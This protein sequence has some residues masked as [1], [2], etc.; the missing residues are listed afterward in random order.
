MPRLA[1]VIYKKHTGNCKFCWR[2]IS[3]CEIRKCAICQT[4]CCKKC[5]GEFDRE[6][7]IEWVDDPFDT[8][9]PRC[10]RVQ[11]DMKLRREEM[12]GI[13]SQVWQ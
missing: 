2:A 3:M 11:L 1:V 12:R 6:Q 10:K 13:S 9:C 5:T 8:A 7:Q 4:P